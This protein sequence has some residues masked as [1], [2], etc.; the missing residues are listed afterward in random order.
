[1]QKPKQIVVAG[2]RDA[3]DTKKMLRAIYEPFLPA[4][5]IL[6]ADGGTAQAELAKRLPFLET[7][8]PTG[9]KATAFVCQNYSCKMPTTDVEQLKRQIAER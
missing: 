9:A 6:L 1:L 5:I 8:K 7:I 4:R 3:A 2:K